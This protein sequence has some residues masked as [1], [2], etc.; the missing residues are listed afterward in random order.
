MTYREIALIA[1]LLMSFWLTSFLGLS[2]ALGAH[3]WWAVKSSVIGS[4]IGAAG[5][6]GWWILLKETK[7]LFRVALLGLLMSAFAAISGKQVFVASYAENGLA[8]RFWF[9]GWFGLYA[10][11]FALVSSLVLRRV[12]R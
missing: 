6:A 12:S 8:G 5:V 4:L 7:V 1:A 2:E 9:F 3:P 10:C 11:L